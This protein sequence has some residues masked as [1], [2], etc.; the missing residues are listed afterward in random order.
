MAELLK[1]SFPKNN[2]ES[3]MEVIKA[4]A[5]NFWAVSDTKQIYK[6]NDQSALWKTNIH[7]LVFLCAVT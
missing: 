1:E 4:D 5:F 6:N 3:L 2:D 7:F